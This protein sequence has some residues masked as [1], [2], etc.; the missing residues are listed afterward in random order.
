[1]MTQESFGC[2][3]QNLNQQ[4]QQQQQ[5]QRQAWDLNAAA[6]RSSRTRQVTTTAA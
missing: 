6:T 2:L 4:Q 1:M 3:G 5:Q